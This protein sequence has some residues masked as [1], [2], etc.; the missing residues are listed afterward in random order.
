MS[1]LWG[2]SNRTRWARRS[3]T[4]R[5]KWQQVQHHR[6]T[7]SSSVVTLARPPSFLSKNNWLLFFVMLHP[8]S[9]INSL[10]LFVN[11]IPVP[12]PSFPTHIPSP[13]TSSSTDSTLCT[14]IAPCL[15]HARFKTYL[16]HKSYPPPVVSLLPLP[17]PSRTI[18]RTVSSELLGF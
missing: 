9:G 16:F 10:Y 6:S 14:S 2:R 3:T 7:R 11:L 1:A 4:P 12:V 18:T 15:F 13:V 5:G 8:V 17:L